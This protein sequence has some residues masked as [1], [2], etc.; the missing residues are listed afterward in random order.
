MVDE[1]V[2]QILRVR[3]AIDPV[4]ADVANQVMTSQP[5]SQAIA[6][7]VARRSIVLLKNEDVLPVKAGVRKIAVIGQNAVLK[8]QSGGVGAGVK[9]LYEVTP[10]EGITRRAGDGVQV[11]YA[12]GYKSFPGRRRGPAPTEPNP[13][14]AAAIDEPADPA[15][16]AEAVSLAREADL[17]F[18]FGGTNKNIET[19]GSDRKDIKL[20][21][22]Q[23]ALVQA[24]PGGTAWKAVR[25]WPRSSS[26]TSLPP[27]SCP[28][29]SPVS[30][31]I[32]PPMRWATSPTR[33]P[34][35]TS[36]PSCIVP[37]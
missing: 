34:V 23:E 5:E 30:W 36:S 10:L 13:L 19:E 2:R 12:P 15:M 24:R 3:F 33:M 17:V 4:P 22:G 9:A 26:G 16:L 20:P 8:T 18:F 27:A 7:E 35:E 29:P 31:R 28:S 1:K 32:L 6:L 14:E 21:C 25:P 37:T 11:S